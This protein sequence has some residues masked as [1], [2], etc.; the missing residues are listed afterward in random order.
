MSTFPFPLSL[1]LRI[2]LFCAA[3]SF[4]F[5][6]GAQVTYRW[7]T[8]AGETVYSD[9][10]PPLGTRFEKMEGG[11][12]ESAQTL[13]YA[14]RL[15]QEKYPVTLYTVA[16]CK[17]ACVNARGLLNG[18]GVPFSEKSI[19]SAEEFAKVAKE[20]GN[21]N[22]V[23]ALEVGSQKLPGFDAGAWNN[24]LD[25]AGYPKTVPPGR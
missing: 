25:L 22:F 7:V 10:P 11:A 16:G 14:T 20:M 18:R 6:C 8:K 12:G 4:V 23:P 24:L 2:L 3:L 1:P 17:N 5:P 13:P 21:E 19:A 9:Q 15:A